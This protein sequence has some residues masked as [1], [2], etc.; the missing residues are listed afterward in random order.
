MRT[1]VAQIR[2]KTDYLRSALSRLNGPPSQK[3][4]SLMGRESITRPLTP[5]SNFTRRNESEK[6]SLIF[7]AGIMDFITRFE[8]RKTNS[9]RKKW[10]WTVEYILEY[11][12]LNRQPQFCFCNFV[13]INYLWGLVKRPAFF[14]PVF[15]LS[16]SYFPQIT[17]MQRMQ[18][19]SKIIVN[20]QIKIESFIRLTKT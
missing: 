2:R 15:C 7:I 20:K 14:R 8:K 19:I 11:A 16:L 6:R 13:R 9:G 4:F 10:I 1:R 18:S 3:V 12:A 5:Q 17:Q